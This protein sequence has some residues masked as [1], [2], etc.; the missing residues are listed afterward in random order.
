MGSLGLVGLVDADSYIWNGWAMG[1]CCT[2]QGT[3][4]TLLGK[5]LMKKTKIKIGVY[6]WLGHLYGWLDHLIYSRN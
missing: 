6:G 1:S 3:L 2:A 5:N 4:S